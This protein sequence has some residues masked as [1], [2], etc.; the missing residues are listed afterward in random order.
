MAHGGKPPLSMVI[1]TALYRRVASILDAAVEI[2]RRCRPD[3]MPQTE[4]VSQR[5][6]RTRVGG[7][8]AGTEEE[9]SCTT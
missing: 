9:E 1:L 3:R 4:P 7:A 6:G 5:G 8:K 2:R